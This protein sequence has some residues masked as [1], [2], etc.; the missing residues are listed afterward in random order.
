MCVCWGGGATLETRLHSP[1]ISVLKLRFR[2]LNKS[3]I[4]C[5]RM[6]TE[7]AW[8]ERWV[9]VWEMVMMACAGG[10]FGRWLGLSKQRCV[11]KARESRFPP[12]T[13]Q[14]QKDLWSIS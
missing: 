2:H 1:V 11:R 7:A 4:V 10:C 5:V 14:E 9:S 6:C 13:G 12:L 3:A 8:V